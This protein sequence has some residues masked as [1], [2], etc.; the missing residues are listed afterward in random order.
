MKI[1]LANAPWKKDGFYGVR[2]GS[3]W[4]HFEK[5]GCTYMPFPFFLAYAAALLRDN[6]FELQLVDAI[7]EDIGEEEFFDRMERF[8]PDVVFF[9]I[10]TASLNTDLRIFEE[11]RRRLGDSARIVL[12]GSHFGLSKP[13]FLEKHVH[14]DFTLTGEYEFNL[15]KLL[16]SL[17]DGGS[18]KEVPGLG[19]RNNGQAVEI[20]KP[21]GL[22]ENLDEFPWPARELLPMERYCDRPGGIPAPSLQVIA[23]RGCPFGCIF[24]AWPQLMYGGNSY[25]SRSPKDVVDEIEDCVKRYGFK[26]FYFDDD[27]FNIGK[28]RVLALAR[29][30]KD[31][32]LNL[33]WA[34][35]ARADQMD[36]EILEALKD[37]GLTALKY[38]V[39]SGSQ[40]LLARACKGLD[41]AKVAETVRITRELGI[42]YHLTFM[43]GLPGE[44]LETA[45]QTIETALSLDPDSLQFSIATPFP[46]SRFHKEL[47][48]RGH[49]LSTNYDDYDGYNNSVVRT[50]ALSAEDLVRV[51]QEA[52]DAWREHRMA[53][54]AAKAAVRAV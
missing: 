36:R 40:D 39:E 11:A 21:G 53:R 17:R 38:G 50:D 26:S 41:L 13:E 19:H 2:A 9:E 44:T 52:E 31:R 35:M 48:E 33:P 12:G 15:L 22:R 7:A 28:K 32:G 20:N 45:R 54:T 46:G 14:A 4:P 42:S 47:L 5:Q 27:T 16:E 37:A 8:A 3:R 23:S 49:L 25:R 30:I 34:I 51:R 18:L 29:E 1:F 43:F 24:C 6:G 10:S